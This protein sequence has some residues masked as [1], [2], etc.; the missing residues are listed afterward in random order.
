[1]CEVYG[2]ERKHAFLP[3]P[4]FQVR[5]DG[6]GAFC[7]FWVACWTFLVISVLCGLREYATTHLV[8]N[9]VKIH[10]FYRF[11]SMLHIYTFHVAW[12]LGPIPL[13]PSKS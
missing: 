8:E 5:W 11:L 7:C 9:R 3:N 13:N 6:R 10:A 12:H 2:G 4:R 1:V